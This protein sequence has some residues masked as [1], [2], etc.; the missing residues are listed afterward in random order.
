MEEFNKPLET[1]DLDFVRSNVKAVIFDVDGVVVQ[2]G[3]FLRESS[4]GTELTMKTH[5]MSNEMTQMVNE[6][7]KHLH[8]AFS[9]GRALLYLQHMLEDVLWDKV[10][11]I[12]ENGNFILSDGKIEQLAVYDENYFQKL[13]DIRNGLKQLQK[14]QPDKVH[15]FEPKHLILSVHT[16]GQMPEI[17]EIVKRHDD[18]NELYCLWTSEGYDIG[19]TGTNKQTALEFLSKKL[20]I[21]ENEIITTGNN[22]NDRE[23]LQFGIG[24]SVDPERVSGRYAISPKEGELGGE[25]LARYLLEAFGK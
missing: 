20:G 12:A 15:G 5:K 19:R 7:K 1:L 24:V 16:A 23:M 14:E 9:S 18:E 22:L 17:A 10:S 8:V 25:I 11:L 21:A 2:T 13:T 3:T 4:D 6:L